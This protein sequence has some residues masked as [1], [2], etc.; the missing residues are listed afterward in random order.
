VGTKSK[1]RG[2]IV[3]GD[4]YIRS[5]LGPGEGIG[6]KVEPGARFESHQ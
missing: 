2:R 3:P 1:I 5:T 6:S 4:K